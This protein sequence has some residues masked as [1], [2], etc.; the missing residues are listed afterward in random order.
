FICKANGVLYENQLIQIG[1]KTQYQ[2]SGQGK[3]AVFYGNKSSLGDLTNFVVQVTN[4][5][6]IEDTGL[7]VHLQQAP[8]S[9]VPAG[10][11]VQ[12]MIHLECFS[13]FVTMP[14][15]NISFT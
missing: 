14:R 2:S 6:A 9:L 7:Q 1:L 11:Q 8:P 10:A 12:H 15:F 3:L 13:E 4:T 5:D